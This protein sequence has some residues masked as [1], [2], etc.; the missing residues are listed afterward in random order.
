MH[1]LLAD[2]GRVVAPAIAES[3]VYM[4]SMLWICLISML[5]FIPWTEPGISYY[6]RTRRGGLRIASG[7]WLG[8]RVRARARCRHD[9]MVAR[10]AVARCSA[11][12]RGAGCQW[13]N[14]RVGQGK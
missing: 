1:L 13:L 6:Y 4:Y 11:I 2:Y 8:V 5:A 10:L 12:P 9:E 3:L 7:H 14:G